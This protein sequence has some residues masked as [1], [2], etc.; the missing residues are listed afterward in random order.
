M[1][2]LLI[3][4][5]L[6]TSL[7]R[8]NAQLKYPDTKKINHVDEYFGVKV[9]DPY[10]WLEAELSTETK[11]WVDAQNKVTFGYLNQIPLR[12][13]LKNQ[14]TEIWNYE[15]ISAPFKEGKFTYFFK[16]NG[17]Q[18]HSVLYRQLENGKEEVFL[19]PNQFSKDGS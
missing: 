9:Q 7:M 10:R 2:K 3:N 17:L 8:L 15:K 6:L 18:Q 4:S 1:K 12:D 11:S 5:F 14:L 16:N 19:D 13:Q